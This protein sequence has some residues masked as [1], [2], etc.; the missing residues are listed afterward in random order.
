MLIFCRLCKK[1]V[2]EL[3]DQIQIDFHKQDIAPHDPR[4]ITVAEVYMCRDCVNVIMAESENKNGKRTRAS[5][6]VG[7]K[8]TS[9]GS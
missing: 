9:R 3:T 5:R 4:D 1:Q 6:K 8:R 2:L 7:T